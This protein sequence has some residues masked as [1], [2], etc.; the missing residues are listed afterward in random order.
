MARIE[1]FTFVVTTAER[2]LIADLAAK[3]QRSQSDAVR[4]VVINASRQLSGIPPVSEKI[5]SSQ[6]SNSDTPAAA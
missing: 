5:N 2:R 3:M 6:K 1:R 4:I